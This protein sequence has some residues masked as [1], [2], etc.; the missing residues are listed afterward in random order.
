MEEENKA[1]YDCGQHN[2]QWASVNNAIFIC[3]NCAALHR[4][5]GL[6]T[7][8]VRSLSMDTW[9]EKQLRLMALGGNAKLKSFFENYDLHEENLQLRY[10][11]RAAEYYRLQLRSVCENIPFDEEKPSYD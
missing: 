2:P 9:T 8:F 7:S 10:S 3:M 6:G 5:M 11:T 4:S 1:C